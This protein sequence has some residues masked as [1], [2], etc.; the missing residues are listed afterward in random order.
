MTSSS[1]SSDFFCL[2]LFFFV[3]FEEGPLERGRFRD[4]GELLVVTLE[5]PGRPIPEPEWKIGKKGEGTELLV[6][7]TA[8]TRK[9]EPTEGGEAAFDGSS[10]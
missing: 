6:E 10:G 1:S 7:P 5:E 8:G 9:L 4:E 2:E 3:D